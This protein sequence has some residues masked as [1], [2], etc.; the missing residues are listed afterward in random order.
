MSVS[1]IAFVV[2]RQGFLYAKLTTNLVYHWGWPWATDPTEPTA[3]TS[4]ELGLQGYATIPSF[5]I[6]AAT[7]TLFPRSLGSKVFRGWGCCEGSNPS[8]HSLKCGLGGQCTF[9]YHWRWNTHL[10][11]LR[12]WVDYVATQCL[13]LGESMRPCCDTLRQCFILHNFELWPM[14]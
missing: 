7:K 2:L 10:R 13:W 4:Q 11:V 6:L 1:L 5:H 8:F 14:R 12:T 3:S 9:S